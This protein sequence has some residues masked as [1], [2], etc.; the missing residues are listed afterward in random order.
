MQG[1]AAAREAA[2]AG[3]LASDR[4]AY[5]W[6]FSAIEASTVR[7][8]LW[9]IGNGA[10]TLLTTTPTGPDPD[11]PPLYEVLVHGVRDVH[12]VHSAVCDAA[13]E[14]QIIALNTAVDDVE[15]TID[16]NGRMCAR[17]YA[18]VVRAE[19]SVLDIVNGV[20]RVGYYGGAV[21]VCPE[22][23]ALIGVLRRLYN[24]AAASEWPGLRESAQSLWSGLRGT[25]TARVFGG[26]SRR[27]KAPTA[28]LTMPDQCWAIGGGNLRHMQC[29]SARSVRD[30]AAAISQS[31]GR[32][33][34]YVKHYVG[35]PGDFQ[36][37][38]YTVYSVLGDGRQKPVLD[39]YNSPTYEL[40]PIDGGRADLYVVARLLLVD[41]WI[42]R[43]LRAASDPSE[44][45]DAILRDIIAGVDSAFN[46][47][48]HGL[49]V[50]DDRWIGV[51]QPDDRPAK[52]KMFPMSRQ[53]PQLC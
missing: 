34:H 26:A 9:I 5:R 2:R 30:I 25:L 23:V 24:P 51:S 17:L 1:L 32:R 53:P 42:M 52:K 48:D 47:L 31:T 28:A 41:L 45:I 33:T 29:V 22:E 39:V 46:R 10:V 16:V 14:G 43:L 35:I 12:G 8:S 27:P 49:P 40:V 18:G 19:K 21:N 38:K 50:D 11:S 20:S 4:E 13:P 3:L 7:D 37:T 36:L 44:R 6:V 15:W